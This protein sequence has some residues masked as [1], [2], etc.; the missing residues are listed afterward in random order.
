MPYRTIDL[1]AGIGGIRRGFELAGGFENVASAEIDE[2]AC[3]TYEHLYHENPRNDVSSFEFKKKVAELHYDILL[4][5]FPCQAFSSVGLKQGFEDTTRGTIFF[6]IAQIIKETMPKVVF[7]ENVENLIIHDKGN[8]FKTIIRTLDEEL[9][10]EIVG[11]PHGESENL[12]RY[13][14]SFVCNSRNFGVPQNRPRVYI[15]AFSRAYFGQHLSILPTS[16]PVERKRGAIFED[17]NDILEPDVDARFFLSSGYLETLEKHR[18]R[19]RQNGYGFGYRIINESSIVHPV[20]NTL[21]AT[22]GSG[23][24][25]NL[26]IDPING[27]RYA[28]LKVTG[29]Y[30]PINEKCIRTM[31][32]IEWGRLQGFVGYGFINKEGIDEFSFPDSMPITQ[33]FKQL[34]NSVTIPVVEEMALFV[35]QCMNDMT[36]SFTKIEARL[37]SMYCGEFKVCKKIQNELGSTLREET[38][39]RY[40]D[41][42]F[43]FK[44]NIPFRNRDLTAYLKCTTARSA[45]ILKQLS[46]SGCAKK[47]PDRQYVF[48]V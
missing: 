14:R 12:K 18:I 29:K 27:K 4:A 3:Q 2:F 9:D 8:T 47:L 11:F 34:G 15:I 19:Q 22:G 17:L 21:L 48:S 23:R 36:K 38:L 32:P 44:Y 7:L 20:A 37:Y 5:G 1:C 45:Q 39:N 40:F 30:S 31:T 35:K 26:I 42:V 43:H 41:T 33:Q 46:E 6:E 16:L 13:S 25:R 24:E 28:G 10:Y